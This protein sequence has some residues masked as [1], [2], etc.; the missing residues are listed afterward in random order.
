MP[1]ICPYG[2]CLGQSLR[3]RPDPEDCGTKRLAET[4][5]VV[6]YRLDSSDQ[7]DKFDNAVHGVFA[8]RGSLESCYYCQVLET[9][10]H[11]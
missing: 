3:G 1:A 5:S 10:N 7:C 11:D 9:R 8:G 2:C 6:Q 4:L